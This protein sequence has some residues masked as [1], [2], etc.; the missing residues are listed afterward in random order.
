MKTQNKMK[1]NF[2]KTK[3]VYQMEATECG[4]AS[5]C[6]IFDYWGRHMP[7]EQMRIETGVSRDGCAAGNMMRCAMKYGFETH[8]Y[9]KEIKSLLKMP[10]PCIIHWNFEHFVVLEGFKGEYAYINDPACGRRRVDMEM[11]ENSY[12]GI[13]MTFK[14]TE[15]FEPLSGG[16]ELLN[17]IWEKFKESKA[18][19]IKLAVIGLLLAVPGYLIPLFSQIFIDKI[20]GNRHIDWFPVFIIGL[21]ATVIAHG[22]LEM[23]RSA[24]MQKIQMHMT[25][26]SAKRFVGHMFRLPMNFYEQRYAGDLVSRV[27]NDDEIN[28]FMTGELTETVI[29]IITAVIFFIVLLFYNLWLTLIAL[30]GVCT[31]LAIA[32]FVSNRISDLT[33]KLEQDRGKLSGVGTAGIEISSTIKASGAANTY[34]SRL[35]GYS[36]KVYTSEQNINKI[37]TI[38]NGLPDVMEKLF[39][40]LILIVGA[41]QT[42]DGTM[43]LGMLSAFSVLYISFASPV[44]QLVGFVKNLKSLRVDIERVND[45]MRYSQDSIYDVKT[46]DTG[47]GMR[48]KL[49]GDIEFKNVSFGYNPM[50]GNIINDITFNV[51]CGSMVAIVGSSGSGKSTFSKL[52]SGLYRAGDGQILFSGKDIKE[53]D[54]EIFHASVATVSQNIALFSGTIRDNITMWNPAILDSDMINAAKDACIHDVITKRE[55]SY[56]Y[57][58]T[59]NAGNMSGGQKQRLEIARALVTNPTVL[60]M[61]EATSALDPITEKQIIDN[62][63]R[64]G[65]T[66]IMIA[67][68]LSAVR[69]SDIIVVMDKGRIAEIGSHESLINENGIYKRLMESGN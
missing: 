9:R 10:M 3:S 26:S 25:V 68:R 54:P 39:A 51:P 16:N 63:R 27:D 24:I 61:D 21:A 45:I 28:L 34:V 50:S 23:Y 43:T 8:G 7:L 47:I 48:S 32:Y 15:R 59:E 18:A 60:I 44:S 37:Q 40:V 46:E 53:I 36:A 52:I 58:L 69:D 64:R 38:A 6:M 57:M 49:S 62:I 19:V 67:H 4:A 30:I 12:T 20:L 13:V 14:P 2:V 55:G 31:N 41:K 11:F 56:D 1:A 35:L 33:Y 66:C 17:G 65:C 29:N 5:L 42:I 22:F